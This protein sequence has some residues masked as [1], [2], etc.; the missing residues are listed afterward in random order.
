M[1]ENEAAEEEDNQDEEELE[2]EQAERN[3]TQCQ[4]K[5]D[6]EEQE[7]LGGGNEESV[8]EEGEDTQEA[9][10]GVLRDVDHDKLVEDDESIQPILKKRRNILTESAIQK[11][12]RQRVLKYYR[13][14]SFYSRLL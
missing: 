8:V 3:D 13:Q 10:D 7:S 9:G 1:Q 12:K 5:L 4:L 14:G 11:L 2:G 6:E